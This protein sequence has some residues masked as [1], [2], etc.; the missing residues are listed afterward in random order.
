MA[1]TS[2]M[3]KLSA[4]AKIIIALIRAKKPLTYTELAKSAEVNRSTVYRC[5]RL[6]LKENIVEKCPCNIY[7][8]IN[9]SLKKKE[10]FK[11][12]AELEMKM[13]PLWRLREYFRLLEQAEKERAH[14]E[15]LWIR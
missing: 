13:R 5:M 10:C 7:L 14:S 6:L 3:K 9:Y 12:S 15:N 2:D 1:Y 8:R 4:D 11:L